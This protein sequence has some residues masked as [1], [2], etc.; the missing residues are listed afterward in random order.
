MRTTD[1]EGELILEFYERTA[2]T[3]ERIA[4][5]ASLNPWSRS[6]A[7]TRRFQQA[8]RA[9]RHFKLSETILNES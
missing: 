5:A 3:R 4:E 2:L 1:G 9:L 6:A 8:E 7:E